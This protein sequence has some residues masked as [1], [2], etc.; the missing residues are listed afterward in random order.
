MNARAQRKEKHAEHDFVGQIDAINR[1]LAVIE[2]ELDGTVIIANANFLLMMG[3][4]LEEI[5]GQHHSMF[6]GAEFSASAAYKEF[7]A[8]LGRGEYQAAEFRRLGK[9][10]REVWI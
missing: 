2:F 10:G 8:A 9:G 3:Y 4:T 5:V 1:P 6:A 7:W